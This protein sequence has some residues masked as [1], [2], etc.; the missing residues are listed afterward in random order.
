MYR[1]AKGPFLAGNE[2]LQSI[3]I[4]KNESSVIIVARIT[5]RI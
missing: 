2:P 1:L 5:Y 3:I 4:G